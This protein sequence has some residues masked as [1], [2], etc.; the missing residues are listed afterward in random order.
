MILSAEGGRHRLYTWQDHCPPLCAFWSMRMWVYFWQPDFGR[1]KS[2]H[3]AHFPKS[4]KSFHLP[5]CPAFLL[6]G[7]NTTICSAAR[8]SSPWV[9]LCGHWSR[10]SISSCLNLANVYRLCWPPSLYHKTRVITMINLL[11]YL[12][13]KWVYSCI[14]LLKSIWHVL[15][16]NKELLWWVNS[17]AYLWFHFL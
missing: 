16:V 2:Y 14:K 17:I 5:K 12:K 8:A 15:Q 9:T 1:T 13:P 6:Y 4:P 3:F 11:D 7:R 10:P